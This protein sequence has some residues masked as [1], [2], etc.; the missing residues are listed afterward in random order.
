M[1][2]PQ[3][4]DDERAHAFR[5]YVEPEVEV[6]LRVARTLTGPAD[7]EDLVQETL[8]RAWRS[9]DR[10]DG[11]H[12]RAWLLTILRNT[13]MNMHRRR[14][15]DT[16]ED[17][18]VHPDARPAFGVDPPGTEDQVMAS[19]LPDDLERAVNALPSKFRTVLLLIDVDQLTYS[20]AGDALGIPVGTVMS[21]LSRARDRVR[22]HLRPGFATSV[23]E[24]R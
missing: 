5:Q 13:N 12:P 3:R 15:P 20:E 16:V 2:P 7:T 19:I 6:L 23:K 22:K 11:R 18:A 4:S 9:V 17:F 8:V 14:R 1:H 10:F 21:R 24:E